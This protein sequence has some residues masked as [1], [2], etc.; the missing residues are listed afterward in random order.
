MMCVDNSKEVTL[1]N[2]MKIDGLRFRDI[3]HTRFYAF[4]RS[5]FVKFQSMIIAKIGFQV[6][7]VK[8]KESRT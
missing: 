4:H 7:G 3:K 8:F 6:Y 1:D 2:S 5:K